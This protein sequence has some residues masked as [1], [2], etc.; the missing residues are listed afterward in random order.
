M[1]DPM[2]SLLHGA[3]GECDSPLC[4]DIE[5]PEAML[6]SSNSLFLRRLP[7][8]DAIGLAAAL[9][10]AAALDPSQDEPQS[11]KIV[12]DGCDFAIHCCPQLTGEVITL[13]RLDF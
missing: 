8:E 2:L 3:L 6:R 5:P 13:H 4:L 11:G 1:G 10:R 9:K 7:L 12:I